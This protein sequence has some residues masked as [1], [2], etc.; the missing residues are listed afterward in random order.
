MRTK[1]KDALALGASIICIALLIFVSY[2]QIQTHVYK[3]LIW[4]GLLI[5]ILAFA[6]VIYV[7]KL[8]KNNANDDQNDDSDEQILKLKDF[9]SRYL[10]DIWKDGFTAEKPEWTKWNAPYFNDYTAY[11]SFSSFKQSSITEYLLSHS[12]K[13][14]TINDQAI[15]MVSKNWIDKTTLWLEI[16]IVIYNPNYWHETVKKFV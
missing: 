15:G 13:A 10:N 8:I 16:G 4:Y 5:F 3:G 12:C 11:R 14:I 2:I 9:N 7:R 1:I 6:S